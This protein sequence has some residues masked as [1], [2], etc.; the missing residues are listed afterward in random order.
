MV[1]T[2][3]PGERTGA[4]RI[5]ASKSQAHRI[6]LCAALG[7]GETV[8]SC[9]G[10]SNDI[11]ATIACMNALGAKIEINGDKI[12][13]SPRGIFRFSETAE[14]PC[15]ESG[16]TLRFLLP[17]V[18]ALGISAVFQMQGRLPERPIEPLK[19][20]LE[21]H[22][23]S[24]E[25]RESQLFCKG[26][27]TPGAYSIPGDVSSQYVSGLLMALPLLGG[28]STIEVTG[29]IESAAYITMTEEVL[30]LGGV[31]FEKSGNTYRIFPSKYHFPPA[32]EVEGDYSNAAFFLCTGAL[33]G[34]GVTVTGLDGASSQ[35]DRAVLD[36]LSQMGA[37]ISTVPG[38]F[39]VRG[40]SLH[41]AEID[42]SPIPDLIPV[43][44]V[45][46][47]AAE[48][49]TR[50]VNAS[51]LRLKESDRLQSTAAMLKALGADVTE[52]PDSLII[53]GGKPLTGGT[54]DSCG[55]HRIAMSAAVAATRCSGSVTVLGSES[56]TKSYPEFW[57]DFGFLK[58]AEK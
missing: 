21:A 4:V 54:V 45:T 14:L 30:R 2:V 52:L 7:G 8:I 12:A 25:K 44:A 36:I 33:S 17:A 23:M 28:E 56:V 43:L 5:P 10:L 57:N 11:S 31:K 1:T 27:L 40:S 3:S 26:Q 41:G 22:G 55:D 35:G 51:R 48:G 39:F 58:G 53:R 42:A 24:I 47:A 20:V 49:E 32:F 18:G 34:K 50:V 38:G 15:S 16:S 19:S 9:R 37:E 46:A 6:I 13:V 29:K